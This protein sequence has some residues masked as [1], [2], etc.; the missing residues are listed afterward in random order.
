L[1]TRGKIYKALGGLGYTLCIIFILWVLISFFD[2][3]A[4]NLSSYRYQPWNFFTWLI[5]FGEMVRSL[6]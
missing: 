2:V 1:D 4:H 3:N 6:I 5:R